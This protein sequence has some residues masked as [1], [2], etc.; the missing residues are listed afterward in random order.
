MDALALLCNLYGDGP[1]TLRR[2]REAGLRG[3]ADVERL[4]LAELAHLLG[5]TADA[6]LRFQREAG[7]L[8]ARV[9]AAGTSAE[10]ALPTDPKL[11]AALAEWRERDAQAQ[12]EGEAPNEPQPEPA[13][14]GAALRP[15]ILD[16][17]DLETCVK[18]R[19]VG[20]ECVE[21]LAAGEALDLAH[22]IDLGVTRMIRLQF[23][24]RRW[25]DAAHPAEPLREAQLVP[26]AP[27]RAPEAP[28]SV[29]LPPRFSPA[30]P[31]SA[32]AHEGPL[33]GELAEFAKR[34]TQPAEEH[35]GSA[36]PFA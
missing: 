10:V 14:A 18:L 26:S 6:A 27:R 9:R 15:E 25:V 19:E 36:G 34:K 4:P 21:D 35:A 2:L 29:H 11:A 1:K 13:V 16:G 17:L 20:V 5:T 12:A 28:R 22:S 33:E 7:D 30:D 3:C 24:A 8:S 32:S 31:G 23:L